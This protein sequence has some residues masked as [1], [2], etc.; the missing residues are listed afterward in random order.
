MKFYKYHGLGNDYIVMNPSE[1]GRDLTRREIITICHRN[2]GIGSDGLLWGSAGTEPFDLRIFNPDASEAEKSGNGLRIF[3]RYLFDTKR[4]RLNKPFSVRTPGGLVRARV[5]SAGKTVNVEMGN[6]S[7]DSQVIP[8]T[9]PPREV[10][11]ESLSVK[12]TNYT[13]CAATVGNPHCVVL[14]EEVSEELARTAGPSI[15]TDPRFPNRTNVQFMK[16]LDRKNIQIEIWERGAGYTLASGSSSSAAAAVARRLGYC[17]SD[18]RVHMPGG[19][20]EIKVNS[21]FNISMTGPVA[22]IGSGQINDEVFS[23]IPDFLV[24]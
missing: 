23:N 11:N 7:F 17:D 1:I 14:V 18:I 13:Y 8:V 10:L 24:K 19:I 20:L 2:Y 16:V 9:G 6:V 4:V 12:G 22:R 5:L 3:A 15:E 21:D